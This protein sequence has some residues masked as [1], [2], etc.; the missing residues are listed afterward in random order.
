MDYSCI[1]VLIVSDFHSWDGRGE[2]HDVYFDF[3]SSQLEDVGYL[4]QT[5]EAFQ[6]RQDVETFVG[7]VG[8]KN[9]IGIIVLNSKGGVGNGSGEAYVY[10]ACKRSSNYRRNKDKWSESGVKKR[11]SGTKKCDCPFRLRGNENCG[12]TWRLYVIDGNHNHSFPV[13]NVGRSVMSRLSE[14]EKIKTKEMTRAHMPPSQILISIKNENKDNLTT[15]KQMYNYMQKIMKEEMEGQK[16][17]HAYTN[18]VLHFGNRTTNRVESAHNSLKRFL[19]TS[20]GN[21]DIVWSRVHSLLELQ[22][23]EIKASFVGSANKDLHIMILYLSTPLTGKVSHMSIKK[24]MKEYSRHGVNTDPKTCGCYLRTSHGLPCSHEMRLLDEEGRGIDLNDVHIFWRTLHME[25][26]T[27]NSDDQ[28]TQFQDDDEILWHYFNIMMKQSPEAKKMYISQ[29]QKLIH[30]E[31]LK[32]EEPFSDRKSKGRPNRS[33]TKRDPSYF[34]HV[35]KKV[36]KHK[37]G[38]NRKSSTNEECF[39]QEIPHFV[40]PYIHEYVD[41]S[42]DENCG[43]RSVAYQIYGSE[44]QWRRVRT[45]LYDFLEGRLDYWMKV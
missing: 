5:E 38:D 28:H 17:V 18:K 1:I 7:D 13:Y 45:D 33:S 34:E 21:L 25:G 39:P 29:L 3:G 36:P 20:T 41:V 8:K 35:E 2:S 26:A 43:Y 44:D 31:A 19:K 10:F 16:F 12:G 37:S 40:V 24:I 42:A 27:Y 22:E 14:D 15:M 6:S 9:N 4:F 30:P 11:N 23:N 32:L